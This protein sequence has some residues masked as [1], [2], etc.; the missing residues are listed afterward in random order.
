MRGRTFLALMRYRQLSVTKAAGSFSTRLILRRLRKSLGGRRL[1]ALSQGA[2]TASVLK[3]SLSRP[4]AS[5]LLTAIQFVVSIVFFADDIV[6]SCIVF[7]LFCWSQF[8]GGVARAI[9]RGGLCATP[10]RSWRDGISKRKR[11]P[12]L[13]LVRCLVSA[14]LTAVPSWALKPLLDMRQASST[15]V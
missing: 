6:D 7:R 5:R 3:N 15:C 4:D 12:G 13:F 8:R 9:R 14:R 1:E 2:K 10:V 11:L